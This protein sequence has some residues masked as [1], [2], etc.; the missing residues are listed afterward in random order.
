M[1]SFLFRL[2]VVLSATDYVSESAREKYRLIFDESKP[3]IEENES[4]SLFQIL[5]EKYR[6]FPH[7]PEPVLK[8]E[9]VAFL[10]YTCFSFIFFPF[11]NNFFDFT[12]M[13]KS[14]DDRRTW[15][16]SDELPQE[17]CLL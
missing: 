8:G 3:Q 16:R 10:T 4:V 5:L 2:Q 7:Q 6:G 11:I 14:W 12:E 9:D 17:L 13:K 1:D 15:Q